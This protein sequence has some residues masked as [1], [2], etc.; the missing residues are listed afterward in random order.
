GEVL[1]KVGGFDETFFMY[2][3]DVDLSYRI[4]QNG[5]KNYYFAETPIIHFKGES[6]RKGSMNYVRMF[7]TAMS[8][9]V[10]KH[11]GGRRAGIFNFLIHLAIGLKAGLTAI[12][13]FIRKIGLPVIDAGLILVSFWL[14]KEFWTE[15]VRKD[16]SY[17]NKLLW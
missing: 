4:Q 1:E 6:T 17:E 14:M 5:Y 11:Y 10:K 15:Y 2:G 7:Y 3:E 16:I 13:Q 8:V 12:G 9:F